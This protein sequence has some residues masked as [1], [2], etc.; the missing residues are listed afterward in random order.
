MTHDDAEE[1]RKNNRHWYFG[2]IYKCPQDPR[3]LVKNKF[4]IGWTW[5]FGHS[6]VLLA[7]IAA[8]IFVLGVPFALAALKLATLTGLI[9]CFLLCLLLVVLLAR[10]VANGPR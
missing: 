2:V 9:V 1:L 7:I 6:Y 4:S 3:L 8:A 5:N 10:Y